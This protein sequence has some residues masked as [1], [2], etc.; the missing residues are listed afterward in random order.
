MKTSANNRRELSILDKGHLQKTY[1]H[2]CDLWEKVS[3][4]PPRPGR[5]LLPILYRRFLARVIRQ[6][7]E[8]KLN[9]IRK[10]EVQ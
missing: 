10:K 1:S 9:E 4:F 2:H 6:K 3:V 5:L 8:I 7:K